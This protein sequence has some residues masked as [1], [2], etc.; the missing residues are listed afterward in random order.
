MKK[1]LIGK[2]LKD[3]LL[4]SA[5]NILMRG[6]SVSF[7]AFVNRRIGAESLGLLTLV[8]SVYGFA[9]TVALSCVNLAAVKI[10]SEKCAQLHGADKKSWKTCM[11]SVVR[12]VSTYSLLFG[13][14][15]GIILFFSSGFIADRFLNDLRT[16]LS[17]KV[18]AFSLPAISLSSA[19][20]GFFTGLR[21]VR[22]N[23]VVAVSE[24]FLK[25]I[26]TS[27]ALMMILPGNVEISCLA[28]VGGSAISEGLSLLINI[29]M[30]VT[31][32]KYPDKEKT[33]SNK[34]IIKTRLR[35][36]ADISL[37]SA[38]GAYARQGLTTIEHLAI[39]KGIV[40]SGLSKEAALASY[41]L[42]QGI[43]FPLVMFPYALIG[44]FTSLLVSE[45]A[46]L[47]EL[48]NRGKIKAL[49]KDVYRYSAMFSLCACGIFVNFANELGVMIYSSEEASVY[50]YMLGLLV[51][52]MYLD[53][54]V[55][56]LLK[57]LGQQV[58]IMG[59]NIADAGAGVL[60]V[61]LL[62]PLMGINGYILTIWICE[63]GNLAASIYRLGKLTGEGIICALKYYIKP[64]VAAV[65]MS[66]ID[67]IFLSAVHPI[68]RMLIFTAGYVGIV[69]IKPERLFYRDNET[70]NIFQK[71]S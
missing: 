61:I 51:P 4:L 70:G 44:S 28:V 53:T 6:I 64:F 20:S 42:L 59:V 23:A 55:D 48:K 67:L 36:T 33:G 32:T 12:S 41:G 11:K 15:S 62:T 49:T 7:N 29:I 52:F 10:T 1:K 34:L 65:V 60:L 19:L 66:I 8:M 21:K 58:Y 56:S 2:F 63:V 16:V 37:P 47:N 9:V 24:E 26:I 3:A 69:L 30:Y 54:A 27:T 68:V 13:I 43:A 5:V 22:K 39:P 14:S 18:L 38:I 45:M 25:I 71:I 50:T 17:L 35:D 46:E 40:K 57:G 31:D